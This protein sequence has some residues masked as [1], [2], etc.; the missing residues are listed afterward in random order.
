MNV[1]ADLL[2][3]VAPATGGPPRPA[4]G[5]LVASGAITVSGGF[6]GVAGRTEDMD[7]TAAQLTALAGSLAATARQVQ[8]LALD[9]NLVA[10]AALSPVT[11]A[12]VE[13]A[14]GELTVGLHGL[15]VLAIAVRGSGV[16]LSTRAQLL[17]LADQ[18]Q[19]VW[20]PVA[21]VPPLLLMLAADGATAGGL[22]GHRAGLLAWRAALLHEHLLRGQLGAAW[23][24]VCGVPPALEDD[25]HRLAGIATDGAE[26]LLVEHPAALEVLGDGLVMGADVLSRGTG[27]GPVTVEQLVGALQQLAVRHGL[28][29]DGPV[30][31]SPVGPGWTPVVAT[32]LT[33]LMVSGARLQASV[34]DDHHA[35]G[36]RIMRVTHAGGGT[37]WVVQVPGTQQ[38][39]LRAGTDPSDLATDLLLSAHRAAGIT[40]AVVQAM[41]AAGITA[42]QPVMLVGHSQ[43]GMVAAALAGSPTVRRHFEIRAVLTA[44]S[45]I[46]IDDIP[47]DV[48]VLALE[49]TQDP[50]PR[51]DLAEN[52]DRPNW[53]TVHRDVSAELNPDLPGFEPVQAHHLAR[54]YVET[55]RLAEHSHDPS[56]QHFLGVARPFLDGVATYRDWRLV[57]G[58]NAPRSHMSR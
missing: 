45:P 27:H 49:N 13:L 23:H 35:S 4:R 29:V 54:L 40:A 20:A 8:A 30:E 39:Q 2:E 51:L 58:P 6:A 55:A 24:D 5:G 38:W 53:A 42:G 21:S 48:A 26:R 3:G 19:R 33:A 36:V 41:A 50:V 22:V 57:R 47:D 12:R 34:E 16:V 28:L 25:L 9:E 52:P 43:G 44:G 31:A 32:S 14:A 10:S 46:S 1:P 18:A 17:R 11:A 15:L 56:V 7:A 37:A